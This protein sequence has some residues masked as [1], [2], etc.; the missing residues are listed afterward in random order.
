MMVVGQYAPK[1]ATVKALL[2]RTTVLDTGQSSTEL[3][4][5]TYRCFQDSNHSRISF[6]S[7]GALRNQAGS[8]GSVALATSNLVI[9]S[10]VNFQPMESR[11]CRSCSSLRAPTIRLATVVGEGANLERFAGPFYRFRWRFHQSPQRLCKLD[12]CVGD[13]GTHL[14]RFVKA[15][16]FPEA[17]VAIRTLSRLPLSVF[18]RISS[19]CPSE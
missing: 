1:V 2:T 6:C 13:R 16:N 3:S 5:L 4:D 10:P 12:S 14:S 8:A 17:V 19:D 7:V 11:F 18:P 15:T 9:C